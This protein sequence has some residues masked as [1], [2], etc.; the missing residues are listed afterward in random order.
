LLA[1]F[2]AAAAACGRSGALDP[3]PETPTPSPPVSPTPTPVFCDPG[4]ASLLACWRFEGDLVDE[5]ASAY[6]FSA[7]AIAFERD[8]AVGQA[9]V[10][11]SQSFL[12]LPGTALV[13]GSASAL[14][15]E[16][17]IRLDAL[18]L[19]GGRFG[20]ID[21]S[22][23]YSVFIYPS[24][25]LRCGSRAVVYASSAT[26]AAGSWHHVACVDDTK[27]TRAYVDG[28]LAASAA[29]SNLLPTSTAGRVNV[30][31]NNPEGNNQLVGAIDEVRIFA[32][33]LD[34]GAVA[35]SASRAD[36]R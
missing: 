20:V 17:W 1:G 36:G 23:P 35:A 14:S 25:I 30:G 12:T 10:L 4:E 32:L 7:G 9:L 26:L 18:P 33:T 3:E 24:G 16:A 5:S 31:E 6:V 8:G 13:V 27:T 2:V 22:T 11:G 21:R 28:A 34:S 19:P 15:M 29:S